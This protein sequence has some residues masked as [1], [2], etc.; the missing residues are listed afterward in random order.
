MH[1]HDGNTSVTKYVENREEGVKNSYDTWHATKGITK[2][3]KKVTGGPKRDHGKT[4][5]VDLSDKAAS[6]RTHMHWAM[7]HCDG[8]SEKLCDMLD[9]IV[10]HY[11]GNHEKCHPTSRCKADPVYEPTKVTLRDPVAERLLTS[12][13]RSLPIYKNPGNYVFCQNTHYVESYNNATLIYHDK[14][15]VFGTAEYARRSYMSII[16]WNENVDRE[17]SSMS[18]RQSASATRQVQGQKNLKP[19]TTVFFAKILDAVL[20][21][22]YQ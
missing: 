9:N 20:Q 17:C 19:K 12:A 11:K 18:Y 15:I 13:I 3:L 7:K 21:D 14:Q 1:I 16:E 2:Q 4:W 5:H 8:S 22:Y 6:I 10:P